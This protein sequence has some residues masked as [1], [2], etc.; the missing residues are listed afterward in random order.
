MSKDKI[1][2]GETFIG[3]KESDDKD[4]CEL[5]I[6]LS[7]DE[8]NAIKGSLKLTLDE[9]YKFTQDLRSELLAI[10]KKNEKIIEA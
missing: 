3:F 5:E 10:A 4:Y 6:V 1:T 9:A 2:V 8:E 7:V